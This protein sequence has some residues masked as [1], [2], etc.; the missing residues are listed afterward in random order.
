MIGGPPIYPFNP[1]SAQPMAFDPRLVQQ[2]AAQPQPPAVPP[3]TQPVFRGAMGK[4]KPAP[5]RRA[6]VVIPTP[7]ELGMVAVRKAPTPLRIPTPEEL[8]VAGR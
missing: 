7:E 6:P 5:V 2:R 8:G 1:A 3:R 4:E